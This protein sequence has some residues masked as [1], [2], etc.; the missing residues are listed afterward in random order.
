MAGRDYIAPFASSAASEMLD[1]LADL[2]A[3]IQ[4]LVAEPDRLALGG[5]IGEWWANGIRVSF[6][7]GADGWVDDDLAFVKPFGFEIGAIAVPTLI[8]HGRLDLF[9]P[10]SHGEWLSHE[11]PGAESWMLED[12]AH[13]SLLTNQVSNVHAWLLDH[14][15]SYRV[16]KAPISRPA[17][18]EGT[19]AATPGVS[20]ASV[21][22]SVRARGLPGP[23]SSRW[24]YAPNRPAWR[25]SSPVCEEQGWWR[26]AGSAMICAVKRSRRSLELRDPR[27]SLL[28][29]SSRL[30][31]ASVAT[32]DS[33][34]TAGAVGTTKSVAT[35][36]SA[37]TA[38][39]V[40]SAGSVMTIASVAT[41]GS[42]GTVLSAAVA[43]CAMTAL[44]VACAGCA[45]CLGCV[46]CSNCVGCVGCVGCDG[47]RFAFWRR[48]ERAAAEPAGPS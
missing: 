18:A 42:V 9:V 22:V 34:A 24:A 26:Q 17:R 3:S 38:W 29:R 41:A 40:A 1:N 46:G 31:V 7:A 23:A 15:A 30:T 48:G 2:A 16:A 37:A 47:L 32:S 10:I 20:A 19:G 21:L 45:W 12:E 44:S 35:A 39:S 27:H 4:T 6:S 28:T 5:P 14:L 11:V 36:G 33:I 8:V 13:L 25:D 43:G